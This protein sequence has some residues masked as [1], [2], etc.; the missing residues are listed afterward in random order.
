MAPGKVWLQIHLGEASAVADEAVAEAAQSPDTP[1]D[2]GVRRFITLPHPRTN[3]PARYMLHNKHVYEL[4]M[5]KPPE[6]RGS[7][8]LGDIVKSEGN[9]Q[10][11]S[12]ID[13]IFLLVPLL[14]QH[15]TK[16]VRYVCSRQR[17]CSH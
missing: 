11:V 8:F 10:L 6:G 16:R 5:A 4:Q 9:I 15:A 14:M 1:V 7:W 12:A 13:P 17:L 3:T 2:N